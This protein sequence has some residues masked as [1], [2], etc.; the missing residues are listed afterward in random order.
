MIY[1]ESRGGTG[2]EKSGLIRYL[3]LHSLDQIAV[4]SSEFDATIF[5]RMSVGS[6]AMQSL[7][8]LLY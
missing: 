7:L 2:D 3:A 4:N 1:C 8:E 5:T 6:V